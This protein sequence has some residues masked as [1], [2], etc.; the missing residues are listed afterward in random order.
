VKIKLLIATFMSVALLTSVAT[1]AT[2]TPKTTAKVTPKPTTT[3]KPVATKKPTTTKK[4]VVKKKKKKV[5][6]RTATPIPSP[7]PVWPPTGFTAN[8]GVYA[9]IPTGRE[10]LGLISAKAGLATDVKKCE[11]NACGAV[12]VATD[13]TCKWWEIKSTVMGQNPNDPTKKI[14][15]GTLRTTDT[16]LMP[17]TYTNILL[18]SDEPIYTAGVVDPATGVAGAPVLRAGITVGNIS[19]ICHKS[20]TD[21][22]LPSNTYTSIR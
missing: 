10:L 9:K 8:N 20:D 13:Y 15:L 5:V 22:K 18:I 7:S 19:A 6:K 3:K 11:Q 16:L 1:A 21:E 12:I 17:K 4:P 2:P 14:L